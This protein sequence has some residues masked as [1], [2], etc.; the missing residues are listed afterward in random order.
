[1]YTNKLH[2]NEHELEHDKIVSKKLKSNKK[3]EN[4]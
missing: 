4:K 2:I 1:M 3:N